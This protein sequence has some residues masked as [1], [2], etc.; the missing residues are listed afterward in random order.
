MF[1]GN[2]NE[3]KEKVTLGQEKFEASQS[4]TEKNHP[5]P[6]LQKN[7]DEEQVKNVVEPDKVL[8]KKEEKSMSF[9]KPKK[10]QM[11]AFFAAFV[12]IAVLLSETVRK[13]VFRAED[14][15]I[16]ISKGG[17]LIPPVG[18]ALIALGITLFIIS[19]ISLF[20]KRGKLTGQ[21]KWIAVLLSLL[22][23]AVG[24]TSYFRY[25][26]FTESKLIDRSVFYNRES[27]YLDV[28][29][30]H[31]TTK[32]EGESNALYYHYKLLNGRSYDLKVSDK[33]M[34]AVKFIDSKI[35]NT[36][37]RSIDNYAIQEMVRLGMYS[38]EEALNLFIL[39]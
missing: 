32:T 16:F 28:S 30:V 19:T 29:E 8:V 11:Y 10:G 21:Q 34:E 24:F 18:T 26:D 23:A 13:A 17:V 33:N 6:V 39:E 37:K 3:E 1:N 38:K 31:A 22:V 9:K 14:S 15:L 25:V 36:A 27:T 5:A 20:N 7:Q 12:L 4:E 35:K 2:K